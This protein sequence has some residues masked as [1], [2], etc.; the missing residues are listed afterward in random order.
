[1]RPG[2]STAALSQGV[3]VAAK[4][5][6]FRAGVL[7]AEDIPVADVVL[8]WTRERPVPTQVTFTAPAAWTPVDPMDPLNNF[9]QRAHVWQR[10][11]LG[12]EEQLIEIGWFLITDWKED[13]GG[14]SVTCLDLMQTV[15]ENPA[16]WPS[17]P[18]KGATLR[19]E[20]YR[21]ARM[22]IRLDNFVDFTI[23]RA[24]EW[25]YSRTEAIRD[26]CDSYGLDYQI[27]PDGYL[28]VWEYQQREPVAH[29]TGRDLLLDSARSAQPRRPNRW[30]VVGE[31]QE[32][33]GWEDDEVVAEDF[34]THARAG[35]KA[36]TVD[37]NIT[38]PAG[39]S[40][41][42]MRATWTRQ[43][44]ATLS[45]PRLMFKKSMPKTG[46]KT[47][48]MRVRSST[49]GDLR[50]NVTDSGQ[51][52]DEVVVDASSWRSITLV[53]PDGKAA[54]QIGV[55]AYG[56][57]ETG[58]WL[59]VDELK[60]VRTWTTTKTVKSKDSKG[61]TV[62]TKVAE[63][64][65]ETTWDQ[66]FNDRTRKGWTWSTMVPSFTYLEDGRTKDHMRATW[67][68]VHAGSFGGTFFYWEKDKPV[69]K[70]GKKEIWLWVRSK[71]SDPITVAAEAGPDG[72]YDSKVVNATGWTQVY[73]VVPDQY[74]LSRITVTQPGTFGADHW[75]GFDDFR[76]LR[77]APHMVDKRW[78]STF[79][80]ADF[81]LDEKGYGM[82]A[83]RTEL[84]GASTWQ[85]V[86][87]A[88]GKQSRNRMITSETRPL[89]IAPDPRIEGGDLISV[90]TDAGEYLT[91]QVVAYSLP[92]SDPDARMRVDVEV[93]QW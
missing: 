13:S 67:K 24:L 79:T 58:R 48:T 62:T 3:A 29:Y 77:H 23:P 9:G 56:A 7:L 4:I 89:E 86:A 82:V 42:C 30:T 55:L 74:V 40:G 25:G 8:D 22:P 73:L 19:S 63:K 69:P 80:A 28:H 2:P 27:K 31:G 64:H 39:V 90:E 51:T 44:G 92:L 14:V 85:Q 71:T 81:P 91:G 35:W 72:V 10:L 68:N 52:R 84:S 75:V 70:E 76:I 37:V 17:S 26:L 59:E 57:T 46:V 11:H 78:T 88:A 54:N 33:Q 66:N 65:S 45:S 61:K 41:S 6:T 32:Q 36:A 83:Q 53:V 21:L 60:I 49:S 87:D 43:P 12:G 47:I 5:D 50:V 18:P 20:L 93:H 15:E 34:D 1:M 38:Y 16:S